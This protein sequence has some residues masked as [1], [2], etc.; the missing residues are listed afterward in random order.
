M[1]NNAGNMIEYLQAMEKVSKALEDALIKRNTES[2]WAAIKE[3]ENIVRK[4]HAAE[5]SE[6]DSGAPAQPG[7]LIERASQSSGPEDISA[8]PEDHRKKVIALVASIKRIQRTSRALASSFLEVIDKTLLGL[9]TGNGNGVSTYRST[10]GLNS[11]SSPILIQQR[12]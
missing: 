11:N 4:F 10:G 7:N 2:I 5:H 12:G 9:S 3:Q 1:H 8:N 6:Y